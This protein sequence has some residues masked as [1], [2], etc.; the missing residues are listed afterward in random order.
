MN[1]KNIRETTSIRLERVGNFDS[2]RLHQFL[3]LGGA[4]CI[5]HPG[6]YFI[7]IYDKEY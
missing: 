1:G 4:I 2:H 5:S 3:R 6:R 7:I